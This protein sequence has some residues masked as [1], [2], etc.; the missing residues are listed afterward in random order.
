MAMLPYLDDANTSRKPRTSS[1][2]RFTK[3]LYGMGWDDFEPNGFTDFATLC[4]SYMSLCV[5][6]GNIRRRKPAL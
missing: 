6:I 5:R 1:F 4:Q 3:T 2:R